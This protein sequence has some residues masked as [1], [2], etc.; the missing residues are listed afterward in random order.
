MQN[1]IQFQFKTKYL[2]FCS[3]ILIII[4]AFAQVQDGATLVQPHNLGNVQPG[5]VIQLPAG[6]TLQPGTF[7]HLKFT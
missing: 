1:F 7:Y 3:N 2:I 4:F 5:Q 6:S